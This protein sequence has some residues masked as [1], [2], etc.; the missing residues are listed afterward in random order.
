MPPVPSPI[1]MTLKPSAS[2]AGVIIGP[3]SQEGSNTSRGPSWCHSLVM[4]AAAFAADLMA[5]MPATA[6]PPHQHAQRHELEGRMDA[7]DGEQC[8]GPD[9]RVAGEVGDVCE[10]RIIEVRA[11]MGGGIA[12]ER[13]EQ[14]RGSDLPDEQRS[15]DRNEDW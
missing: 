9:C 2:S 13:D 14:I 4:A 12:A 11:E 10:P 8:L 5:T 7:G 6:A 3:I 1:E 15:Q